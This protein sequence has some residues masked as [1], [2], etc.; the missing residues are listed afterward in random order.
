M[1]VVLYSETF[2]GFYMIEHF[3]FLTPPPDFSPR[4]QAAGC[5]CEFEDK[6]LFLKRQVDAF[7]PNTW[8]VPGGKLE[9]GEDARAAV[10][11]EVQEEVGI[12]IDNTGLEEVGRLYIRLP[13]VDYVFHMFRMSFAA[14]PLVNLNLKE[15]QEAEWITIPQAL[16]LPLIAGGKEALEYY[17]NLSMTILKKAF[18]FLRHGESEFA[19]HPHLS[20]EVDVDLT[21]R[22]RKQAESI[23]PILEKLPIQTICVSP[24]LRAKATKD[25]SPKILLRKSM[26]LTN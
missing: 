21:P 20:D 19:T 23:Q 17:G 2:Q 9:A 12:E 14:R 7:Q 18:Y 8:G 11:R 24:L 15:H 3:V 13:H 10:I 16:Q 1:K 4:A 22:G 5:Y 25:L 6:I 26:S